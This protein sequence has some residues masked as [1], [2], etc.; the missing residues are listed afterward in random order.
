MYRI[1]IIQFWIPITLSIFGIGLFIG[2]EIGKRDT[3]SKIHQ[4]AVNVGAGKWIANQKTGKT[5][6]LWINQTNKFE[7]I[8]T[9]LEQLENTEIYEIRDVLLP[10]I[11]K[12]KFRFEDIQ[13]CTL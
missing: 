1:L 12:E 11:I 9:L 2:S 3:V 13:I 8:K 5:E 6:F 10:K 7:L 4:E